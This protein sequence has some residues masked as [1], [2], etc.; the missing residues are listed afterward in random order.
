MCVIILEWAKNKPWFDTAFIEDVMFAEETSGRI[1]A[2]ENIIERFHI[3]IDHYKITPT[4]PL[5][6]V[7]PFDKPKL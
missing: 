1:D 7:Y 4:A 3:P 2:L 6:C 5:P